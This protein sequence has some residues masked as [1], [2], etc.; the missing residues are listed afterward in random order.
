MR[1]FVLR[2]NCGSSA[3]SSRPPWPLASTAGTP[4][5][6]DTVAPFA[7]TSASCPG[8][9]VTSRR[10]SGRKAMPQGWFS[11]VAKTV[12]LGTTPLA[13]TGGGGVPTFISNGAAGG[14][15]GLGGGGGDGGEGVGAGAG[16]GAG[17]GEPPGGVIGGGVGVGLG[18]GLG[19]GVG[20]GVGDA[21]GA[22]SSLPPQ[23]TSVAPATADSERVKNSALRF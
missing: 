13:V 20:P 17:V 19:A 15:G 4:L 14:G 16:L 2:L 9:C 7:L 22:A 12:S 18:P 5:I 8:F 21:T 6:V 23:A 1:R 11:P 10:P 3:T